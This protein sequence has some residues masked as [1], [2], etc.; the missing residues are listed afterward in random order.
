[1]TSKNNPSDAASADTAV[2]DTASL[3]NVEH[4]FHTY[5]SNRIPWYVRLVWLLFWI[6]AVYYTLEYLFPELRTELVNRP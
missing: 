3:D 6:F 2:A 5:S 1:M 4:Q